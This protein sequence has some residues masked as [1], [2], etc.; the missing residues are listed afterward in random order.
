MNKKGFT[1]TEILGV[2]VIISLLLIL[3]IP[4]IINRI[5]S[6]GDEAVEAENQIIYDAADQYIR[7][8]PED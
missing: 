8:H 5:S 6:S 7:E 1:L 3:V 2:I 4:G